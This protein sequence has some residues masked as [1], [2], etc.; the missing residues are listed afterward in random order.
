MD[1][2]FEDEYLTPSYIPIEYEQDVDCIYY[3]VINEE[4]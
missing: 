3:D 4:A 1:R 2:Y